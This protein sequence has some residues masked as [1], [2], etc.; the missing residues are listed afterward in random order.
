M[1]EVVQE[2]LARRA[3]PPA[4]RRQ[5][6]LAA[7][8]AVLLHAA[9]VTAAF[10]V[11]YL[12]RT[13]P[14]PIEYVEVTVLPPQAL[15]AERPPA[16]PEPRPEPEPEPQP[17]PDPEPALPT[18]ER[19]PEPPPDED[20]ADEPAP[21]PDPAPEPVSD[22]GRDRSPTTPEGSPEG[23]P[24]GTSRLGAEVLGP[25][26]AG[27]AYDYYLEQML[28]Q[29]RRSW[30]RPPLEGVRT[31]VTFRV[32]ADGEIRD[33]AV[34]ESSGSRSFDLA[35]LRAVRNASPLPPL[36]ASYRRGSLTVN[37]IVR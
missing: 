21:A 34:R 13:P 32:L 17:E 15:G 20:A 33:A 31:V 23:A 8:L 10:A 36:P 18:P 2:I 5:Q 7:T 16:P 35:A 28:S 14:R 22:A 6:K 9:V 24:G 25:D 11:P 26:G 12:N 29:I 30:V 1:R 3:A 27:F 37:L 19:K 4:L